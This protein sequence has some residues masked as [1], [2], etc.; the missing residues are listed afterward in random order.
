MSYG[1]FSARMDT[2]PLKAGPNLSRRIILLVAM[3]VTEMM[4]IMLAFQVFADFQCD[5]TEVVEGCRFLRS[6]LGRAIVLVA[7]LVLF[8][9]IC[10]KAPAAASHRHSDPR[11]ERSHQG[12]ALRADAFGSASRARGPGH[13]WMLVHLA[14]VLLVLMPVTLARTSTPD[15]FLA[16]ALGP[17]IL[18]SLLAV[19]GAAVWLAAPHE[20]GR[21][22]SDNGRV[23]LPV[24]AFSALVPDL[25]NLALPLWDSEVL[26]SATFAA[27]STL[28][29][30]VGDSIHAD[31]ATWVI[32]LEDFHVAVGQACSG[33]EGLVL[34]GGFIA[35]YGFLFR[36]DLH[37]S[38]YWMLVLPLGLVA[39]WALNSIRIF[40]LIVIGARVSP[41]LAV[42]GFHSYAGWM[43]F[44]LL[45]FALVWAVHVVSFIRVQAISAP[46]QQLRSDPYVSLIVPITVFLVTGVI[47]SAL[48]PEPDLVF[49]AR[50]LALGAVLA[51]FSGHYRELLRP[52][53]ML[54]VLAGAAVGFV[55]LLTEPPAPDDSALRD[56][57]LGL[58]PVAV[59][60]WLILRLSGSVLFVP[61]AE[62]LFFRGYLLTRLNDGSPGM[63]LLAVVISSGLF[64]L[65]HGRWL[66]AFAAGV[67]FALVMVRRS[68]LSDAVVAHVIA[69]GVIAAAA[70][71]RG[72]WFGI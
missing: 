27:V 48:S 69:N 7:A 68:R 10:R 4:A 42:G 11:S 22:I 9:L 32:G 36:S 20:W 72:D 61:L 45:A 23:L 31:P 25:A 70:L 52:V 57:L 16:N 66:A 67:V 49:P 55:W 21:W 1:S 34:T 59:S 35:L 28:L 14:G 56:T 33:I 54:A 53:D 65:L 8:V 12:A 13:V 39:S 60:L 47:A 37:M 51:F 3:V 19:L 62:E 6:L 2:H 17:W 18:G 40:T 38:R 63:R 30:L 41:E 58:G 15:A 26:T 43:F 64:A 71:A 29:E 46:S 50:A 44:S 5:A 24:V